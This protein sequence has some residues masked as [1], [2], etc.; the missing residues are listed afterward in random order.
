MRRTAHGLGVCDEVTTVTTLRSL[1]G[2]VD[3]VIPS[4]T[5][6]GLY[7]ERYI[8]VA[9][10][11]Q[12]AQQ[13]D[14]LFIPLPEG[15]ERPILPTSGR[16][17][18]SHR[19]P[20]FAVAG[21]NETMYAGNLGRLWKIDLPGGSRTPLPFRARVTLAI[22]DPIP[23]PR[24]NPIEP[25]TAAPV[26]TIQQPR[27]SPDGSRLVF[28]AVGRLWQ[29]PLPN[30][31]ASLVVDDPRGVFDP[32]FSPDGR[33][34][35]YI[36]GNPR[37]ERYPGTAAGRH[38]IRIFDWQTG[39]T[40]TLVPPDEC[41]YEDLTWSLDGKLIATGCDRQTIAIDPTEGT[42]GPLADARAAEA[43]PQLAADGQTLYFE[44]DVPNTRNSRIYRLRLS[45]PSEPEP[46]LTVGRGEIFRISPDAAWVAL[47]AHN[48]LGI[49][50]APLGVGRVDEAD[51]RLFSTEGGSDFSFTPDGSALLYVAGNRL[52][53]Q[54]LGGG[55][56]EEIPV[57]LEARA[58]TPPPVLLRNARVLDFAAGGFGSET[59]LLIDGGRIQW[60]GSA[61]GQ[62]LPPETVTLDARGRFAIPGLFD[63]HGHFGGCGWAEYVAVGVTS[64]RNMGGW[65]PV[66]NAQADRGDFSNDP[67]TRCFYTG[68]LFEGLQG[69]K[70]DAFIHLYDEDDARA[71]VRLWKEL[72][73]QF[74][75][76]YWVL[77]WPLHRAAAD[78][79]R[80]LGLPVTAHGIILDEAVKGVT[81]GYTALTHWSPVYDD[82]LQLFAAAGTR[83]DP[84][85]GVASG[86]GE[87]LRRDEPERAGGV[88][89]GPFSG[90]GDDALRG[91]WVA[92]LRSI[93][94]AYR[95]GITLLPGTDYGPNAPALHW[96]LEFFAEA[97]I[98][99]LDVLRFATQAS[100]A[101]VGA[102]DDLG[103]LEVGKLADI[104]LLD[105]NPLERIRNT[106]SV[107]RVIKGGWVFDPE[108]LRPPGN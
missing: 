60:I 18:Y 5:G 61:R 39:Q 70:S 80:R 106:R 103:T 95:R 44:G 101:T 55:E 47:P 94:T 2:V 63:I 105:A 75:K 73:A 67:V 10:R 65:L 6:G 100:A 34:L 96:E 32:A 36:I 84:T 108:E 7:A 92:V 26:K 99:P 40:R 25:G 16:S 35:A 85:L 64:V 54:P 38:E 90:L 37:R 59:S 77:P 43:Y 21:D 23:P 45:E 83:W 98:P 57:R 93:R 24:W 50:L 27:L 15:P 51:V 12:F 46:L 29:Q 72:G 52:W 49:R 71:H 3:P 91:R 48:R 11:E 97:G 66:A 102:G 88:Q 69:R 89:P 62:Q 42:V 41:G 86:G 8:P 68:E 31:K 107:W 33:K 14:I 78:E 13:R 22:R 17:Y 1:D 56:R 74:I 19:E 20:R 82:V 87:L 104:V 28:R 4:P 9:M 58:P 79:A 81:L 76:L 30:G 53:R